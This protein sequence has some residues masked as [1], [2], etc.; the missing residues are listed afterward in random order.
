MVHV[1]GGG[2]GVRSRSG[3]LYA[4]GGPGLLGVSPTAPVPRQ[5]GAIDQTL[6]LADS[7][8]VVVG[9]NPESKAVAEAKQAVPEGLREF[10][11]LLQARAGSLAVDLDDDLKIRLEV[12]LPD[13]GRAEAA[14]GEV[15]KLIAMGRE[16][17]N[18]LKD[19]MPAQ[20]KEV[21]APSF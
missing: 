7:H 13:A 8:L 1:G 21:A 9:F 16:G 15:R 4:L 14:Q 12:T 10:A 20:Y 19:G 2:R 11:A 6:A 3:R 5:G 17:L 18:G